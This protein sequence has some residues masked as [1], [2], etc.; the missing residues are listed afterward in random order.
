M[1]QFIFFICGMMILS[2]ISVSAATIGTVSKFSGS[3]SFRSKNNIPYQPMKISQVIEEGGWIKTGKNGWVELNLIDKS[4]FIIANNT[5]LE[6]ARLQIGKDKKEGLFNLTQGKLR[7]KV[8]KVPGLQ[9]SI[10]VTSKTVTAGIKGTEF[11]MLSEGPANVFFGNE[12]NV[13]ISGFDEHGEYLGPKTMTQ[14]TRGYAPIEPVKVEPNTPLADAKKA[15]EAATSSVPPDD[16]LAADNIQNIIARWNINYGHYL[17]DTGKF[18]Q[19]L[20]VFQIALDLT[21]E[22][23]IRCDA[24][25][26]RG[27]VYSRFLAN[28]EAALAENLLILE[29]Y[30]NC[31]GRETALFNAGQILFELSIKEQARARFNDYLLNYPQGKHRSNVDTL[32]R[33]L[34]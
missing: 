11:M 27:S 7:A 3:A 16:W 29:E 26:E 23:E 21:K 9:T 34:Q 8:V 1:K 19:A 17:A 4:K 12:G 20:Q 18:E 10:L 15:F 5:E 24:R 13:R 30:P 33:L 6:L 28:S 31:S 25:L 2:A 32:L 22:P 14:T